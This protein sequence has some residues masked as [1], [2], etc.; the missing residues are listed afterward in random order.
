MI[1]LQCTCGF[2]EL[3]DEELTDHLHRVFE[4]ADLVGNDG[5][6]HEEGTSLMCACGLAAITAEEL[7]DHFLKVF[8]P[9]D[10]IGRDGRKHEAIGGA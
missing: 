7:D 8:M 6:V 2:T 10:A 1:A 9:D 3:D 5:Q 4:P